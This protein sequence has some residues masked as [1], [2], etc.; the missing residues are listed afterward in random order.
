MSK[1]KLQKF[2]EMEQMPNVFQY[3]FYNYRGTRAD[4]EKKGQWHSHFGNH[5]PIVLELGCGR[6]E[7]TVELA[8][9][10]PGCNFIGVDIK[11]ARMWTGA[12]Q[13]L[14]AGL[15][16]VAF[17]RT[18]IEMID[19]IFAPGE[20][21]E[22][23]LTFPDPQMKKP[24]KRLTGTVFLSLYQR[25]MGKSGVIN[26]KTDS[27]FMFT[28]TRC[29]LEANNIKPQVQTDDLYVSP[30]AQNDVLQIKTYYETQWLSRGITIKYLRF[31]LDGRE[32]YVEPD[33]EI[34]P[35]SYRSYN[36]Q[37]RNTTT[38]VHD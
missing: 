22:I 6:G 23:W 26:L 11:G 17:V 29:L 7:Y 15:G 27:N 8:R 32:A 31:E 25:I 14:E 24:R 36:R 33:V 35:D 30:L 13:A 19:T 16:N 3:T 2:S 5:N 12:K 21:S 28:Y 38:K 9:K 37:A 34:E 1:G 10:N 20:V 18:S 4:Y